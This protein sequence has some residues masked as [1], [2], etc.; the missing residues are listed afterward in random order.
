M[1]TR[2]I[3][4][5]NFSSGEFDPRLFGRLDIERRD[6]GLAKL[7]NMLIAPG[8][9][10]KIRP[11][12]RYGWDLNARAR[13]IG[14]DHKDGPLLVAVATNGNVYLYETDGTLVATLAIPAA[15]LDQDDIES[16]DWASDATNLVLATGSHAPILIDQAA[17]TG[18]FQIG[19][20]VGG[21][22]GA[23]QA[24][25]YSFHD[26]AV[27][28]TPSGTSGA[29]TLTTSA[30][31]WQAAHGAGGIHI[32]HR[33]DQAGGPGGERGYRIQ[34]TGY[35]SSTVV[36]ATVIDTLPSTA[37]STAWAERAFT[38]GFR[39]NPT[40]AAFHQQR[41]VLAG[42]AAT[43]SVIFFSEVGNLRSFRGTPSLTDSDPFAVAIAAEQ[44]AVVRHLRSQGPLI[45]LSS[46]AE[47]IIAEQPVTADNVAIQK[48]SSQGAAQSV[49]PAEASGSVL[50]LRARRDQALTDVEQ[51]LANLRFD[52]LRQVYVPE[53]IGIL[54]QHLI[55]MPR[56]MVFQTAGRFDTNNRV[57]ILNDAGDLVAMHLPRDDRPGASL[58]EFG[59]GLAPYSMA[60]AGGRLFIVDDFNTTTHRVFELDPGYLLDASEKATVASGQVTGL[61]HLEGLSVRVREDD[62]TSGIHGPY[63]VSAGAID[64][65]ADI[66]DST[67]VEVGLIYVWTLRTLELEAAPATLGTLKSVVE[68]SGQLI[69]T[70]RV[71]VKAIYDDGTVNDAEVVAEEL[72]PLGAGIVTGH[73]RTHVGGWGLAAQVELSS[74]GRPAELLSLNIDVEF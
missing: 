56:E 45:V 27:S 32:L 7:R 73:Q 17:A 4:K 66:P 55:D 10:V 22:L 6:S 58:I 69:A 71:S 9:A 26:P 23:E 43:A 39:G 13:L 12:A 41:L 18:A 48:Q 34:I 8:G 2:R 63:T 16:L 1:P 35:V 40:A 44:G 49:R 61:T 70:R 53:D 67:E 30:P 21:S 42:A 19:D 64:V 50:F 54:G 47:F 38:T 65:S 14:W 24:A 33:T 11:G 31:Y 15:A 60:V 28:L 46:G 36:N 29:I 59:S 5:V 62:A 3:T 74:S 37:A 57:W 52:E 25:Y 51:P 20:V 72:A 68:V